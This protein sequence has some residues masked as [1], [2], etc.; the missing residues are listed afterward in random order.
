MSQNTYLKGIKKKEAIKSITQA[1]IDPPKSIRIS[2]PK[3][4]DTAN[5]NPLPF[6]ERILPEQ[7]PKSSRQLTSVRH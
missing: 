3:P 1:Y 5:S 7:N 4:N 2:L 6:P